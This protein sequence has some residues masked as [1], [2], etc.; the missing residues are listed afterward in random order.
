MSVYS[1]QRVFVKRMLIRFER[2]IQRSGK[3]VYAFGDEDADFDSLAIDPRRC[4]ITTFTAPYALIEGFYLECGSS[5]V[6]MTQKVDQPHNRVT[7]GTGSACD[8]SLMR[9]LKQRSS[10]TH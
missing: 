9:E 6:R 2:G 4:E 10:Y 3:S 8:L 7:A 5:P 1:P